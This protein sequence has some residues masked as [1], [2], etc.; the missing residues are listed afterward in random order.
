MS[1]LHGQCNES[2]SIIKHEL[3]TFFS[4]VESQDDC[5][6]AALNDGIVSSVVL[7]QSDPKLKKI[8]IMVAEIMSAVTP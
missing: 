1:V 5:G 4:K 2:E 8:I 7:C 6:A 3:R